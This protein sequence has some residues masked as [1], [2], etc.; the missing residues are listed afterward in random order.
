[1]DRAKK[2]EEI[3]ALEGLSPEDKLEKVRA[4]SPSLRP[5]LSLSLSPCTHP[6]PVVKPAGRH[7][8]VWSRNGYS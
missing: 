2:I 3:R 5:A 6:A 8:S 4:A 1:M 7:R